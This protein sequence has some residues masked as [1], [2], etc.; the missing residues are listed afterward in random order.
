MHCV[1]LLLAGG[2][3][4]GWKQQENFSKLD[5]FKK[6]AFVDDVKR[7]RIELCEP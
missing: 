4:K 2:N 3:E 6:Q 7:E 5:F 1:L